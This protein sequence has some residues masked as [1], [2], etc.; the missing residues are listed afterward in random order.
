MTT[1]DSIAPAGLSS[2]VAR[3]RLAQQG[4]NLPT[5]VSS[6]PLLDA[7]GKFW[8]PVPCMLEM[9]IVVELVLHNRI[10]AAVIAV[11]LIFN[12]ALGFFRE[13]RS[14]ATL[15]ALRSRLALVAS[16][17]RDNKWIQVPAADIVSDDLV[18]TR[19]ILSRIPPW[20]AI[21]RCGVTLFSHPARRA[22]RLLAKVAAHQPRNV[23]RYA[24]GEKPITRRKQRVK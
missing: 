8:A 12:A 7:L 10:E 9:V 23:L 13:N 19:R 5:D 18:E 16:V 1:P 14:K 3:T 6:N 21:L 17:H 11:I 4:P 15:K 20:A 22:F 2:E 24:R